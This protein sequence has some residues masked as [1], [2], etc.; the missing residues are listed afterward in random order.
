MSTNTSTF[1]IPKSFTFRD[2]NDSYGYL[3]IEVEGQ[4]LRSGTVLASSWVVKEFQVVPKCCWRS[5][6]RTLA[7]S[8]PDPPEFEMAHPC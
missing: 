4:V 2:R 7:T 5:Y 3:E 1:E 6:G 8:P